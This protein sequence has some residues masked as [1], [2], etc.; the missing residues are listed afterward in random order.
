[1]GLGDFITDREHQVGDVTTRM[2]IKNVTLT[3]DS[4]ILI[5][6]YH[7]DAVRVLCQ[8]ME[9]KQVKA[10]V[11]LLD[12]VLEEEH[13]SPVVDEHDLDE[14]EEIREDIVDTYIRE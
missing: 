7:T 9:T 8:N 14:L 13:E 6:L 2:K 4:W 1:M 12:E 3:K 10:L 5:S 11:Q